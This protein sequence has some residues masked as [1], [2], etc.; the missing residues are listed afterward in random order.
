VKLRDAAE[1]CYFETTAQPAA[2]SWTV[3]FPQGVYSV[4]LLE[5]TAG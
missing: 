3:T 5:I 1:L 2:G 4:S